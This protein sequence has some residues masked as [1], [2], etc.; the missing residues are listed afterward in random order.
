MVKRV[1]LCFLGLRPTAVPS[2]IQ[3]DL[4]E[5]CMMHDLYPQWEKEGTIPT[6]TSNVFPPPSPVSEAQLIDAVV[7]ALKA[8]PIHRMSAAW[9]VQYIYWETMIPGEKPREW[10]LRFLKMQPSDYSIQWDVTMD[11]WCSGGAV[12]VSGMAIARLCAFWVAKG[13]SFETHN[14]DELPDFGRGDEVS[15]STVTSQ[16]EEED[17]DRGTKDFPLPLLDEIVR[18]HWMFERNGH[19]FLRCLDIR[20]VADYARYEYVIQEE[21]N[22]ELIGSSERPVDRYLLELQLQSE[23]LP[24]TASAPYVRS[25]GA[26][27]CFTTAARLDKSLPSVGGAV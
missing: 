1:N 2:N 11:V 3:P 16:V 21:G 10:V 27:L 22:P 5:K 17:G 4:K 24:I 20:R 15:E 7:I 26:W 19:I 8:S 23:V 25:G 18:Y 13:F 9:P 12:E 14:I 6:V